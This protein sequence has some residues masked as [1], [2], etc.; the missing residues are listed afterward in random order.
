[1]SSRF[2]RVPLNVKT[3]DWLCVKA[4]VLQGSIFGQRFFLIYTIDVSDDL[5]STVKLFIDDTSLFSALHVCNI[6][7]NELNNDMQK[8]SEWAYEWKMSFNPDLDK[9]AQEMIFSRKLNK[10]SHPKV[11]FNN[12]VFCANW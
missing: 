5:V 6:S 3:S 9:Q 10:S 4:V 2:Q 11:F 1:M 8:I 7:A 12:V